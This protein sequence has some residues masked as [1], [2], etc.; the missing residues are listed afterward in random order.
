MWLIG[1]RLRDN[2][3]M[4]RAVLCAMPPLLACL[5]VQPRTAPLDV[6]SALA[7]YERAQYSD[8]GDLIDRAEDLGGH[9]GAFDTQAD[10][11]I[12]AAGETARDRRRVVAASVALELAHRLRKDPPELPGNYLVWASLVMRQ[13]SGLSS[14]TDRAWHIAVLAG[15]EELDF[16]WILPVGTPAGNQALDLLRQRL[17]QGG[18]LAVSLKRFPDEPR[19]HLAQAEAAEGLGLGYNTRWPRFVPAFLDLVKKDATSAVP[20]EPRSA[21]ERS[22]LARRQS[23]ARTLAELSNLSRVQTGFQALIRFP[24]LRGEIELHLGYLDAEGMQW[25]SALAHFAQVRNLT[26]EPYL[27]YLA[28]YLTG[29]TLQATGELKSAREAFERAR[30]ILPHARSASTQLAVEL[31]T[32]DSASDANRAYSLLRFAYAAPPPADPWELFDHGDAR[33]WPVHMTRLQEALK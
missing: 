5:V 32:T 11:W 29:R 13:A 30:E 15:M 9:F 18:Q 19:F 21:A 1:S 22:I 14:E 4:F 28:D 7:L 17:G 12:A 16:P 26:E 2:E 23:A 6:V 20:E 27:R 3:A 24:E 25:T 10:R 8:F 33:L 31:L